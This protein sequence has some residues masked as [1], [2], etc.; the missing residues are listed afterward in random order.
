MR[1]SHCGERGVV[2]RGAIECW[3]AFEE[4]S[5]VKHTRVVFCFSSCGTSTMLSVVCS[6]IWS[7]VCDLLHYLLTGIHTRAWSVL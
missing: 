2:T 1:K 3:G 4:G 6:V 5:R 7:A